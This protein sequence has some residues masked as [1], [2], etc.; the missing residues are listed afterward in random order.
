MQSKLSSIIE[1]AKGTTITLAVTAICNSVMAITWAF[2]VS[3]I[4]STILK[5]LLRRYYNKKMLDNKN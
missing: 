2:G 5:Y 4:V 1:I 3:L